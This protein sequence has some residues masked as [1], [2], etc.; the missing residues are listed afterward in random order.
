MKNWLVLLVCYLS[1]FCCAA[2][3]FPDPPAPTGL[4]VDLTVTTKY[5]DSATSGKLSV[6]DGTLILR[7]T[8]DRELKIAHPR[9]KWAVSFLVL[10]S[11]GAVVPPIVPGDADAVPDRTIT[12][13]PMAEFRE[14]F[15]SLTFVSGK[16]LHHVYTFQPGQSYRVTTVYRPFGPD[17]PSLA[18]PEKTF[19]VLPELK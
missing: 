18:I 15:R 11:T 7:N 9:N 2:S 6:V 19:H 5:V 1:V 13:K 12:I 14:T 3:E 4:A 8:S 10:D 17:G 16:G